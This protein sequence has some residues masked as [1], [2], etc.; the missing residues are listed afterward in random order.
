ML[1]LIILEDIVMKEKIVCF[2][3]RKRKA[4]IA[5]LIVVAIAWFLG[6]IAVPALMKG[7]FLGGHIA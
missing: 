2:L 3:K 7:I 5:I 1:R 4:I 6:Q